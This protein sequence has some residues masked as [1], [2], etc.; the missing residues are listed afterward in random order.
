VVILKIRDAPHNGEDLKLQVCWV[1]AGTEP[2]AIVCCWRGTCTSQ[3]ELTSRW[4][5]I[6]QAA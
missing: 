1:K 4:A 6:R 5:V 2:G 3:G